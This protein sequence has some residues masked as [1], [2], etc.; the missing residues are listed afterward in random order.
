M[1]PK[2]SPAITPDQQPVRGFVMLR[3]YY[4]AIRDLPDQER[5]SILDAILRYGFDGQVPTTLPPTLN[6]YFVLL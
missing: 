6:G 5:L 1:T 4:D 3:S 2:T